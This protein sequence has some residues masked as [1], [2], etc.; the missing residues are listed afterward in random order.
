MCERKYTVGSVLRVG[1]DAGSTTVKVVVLDEQNNMIFNQYLRH[2]FDIRNALNLIFAQ[3]RT[4]LQNK[5]LAVMITGSSGI[6]L[7]NHLQLPFLQEVI[8][9]TQAV[10]R[11]IPEA[12]TVIE[13]GGEDAKITYFGAGV[14]QRMNNACAGGTGAFIDQ[15]AALL[16][17][18]PAGLNQLA[19]GYK[20]IYPIASRCGVFAKTD[21]QNLLNEGIPQ[22]DIAA[23]IL[24]AIVNQTISGLAQSRP[25]TGPVAFLGGPLHFMPELRQRFIET[26]ALKT[27]QIVSPAQAQ[28]FPAIGAALAQFPATLR[29]ERLLAGIAKLYEFA[30]PDR[31]KIEPLFATEA[32]Y[33]QFRQRHNNSAVAR[34][35]LAAYAGKAYLGIDAGSTTAKLAL[36]S[37]DGSLLYSHYSGNRGAPLENVITAL[38]KLY[39]SLPDNLTI[40]GSTVTGYGERLIKTA[41][42]A[43]VGEVET[44]AHYKASSRFLPG[45][46]FVLDIGGQDMKS[47]FVRNGVID[48]IILNEACSA[49]CG[50]FIETFA[51]SLNM[52]VTAFAALGLTAKTPV[53]L[54]SRCTVFMNSKVRQAQQEGRDMGDISAGIAIAIVKNA[55]YKVI[56]LKNPSDLGQK[57]VVQGGIFYNDAVLRALEKFLGREVVRPDI[58]GIMGAYGAALI[59]R[60]RCAGNHRSTILNSEELNNFTVQTSSRRCGLCGNNCLITAQNFSTGQVFRAGNR[61]EQGAGQENQENKENTAGDIPNI[62]NFKYQRVFNYNPLAAAAARRGTIGIPRVLNIY[63]DYPFWFT[64][65]TRLGYRVVLS[66]PSSRQLYETGI[67]AIPSESVCYPAKLVHGHMQDL[68]DKGIKKIFYPCI[69]LNIKEDPAADNCYNCPVVASYPENI[70]ANMDALVTRHVTFYHPFLPLDNPA[71]MTRRLIQELSPENLPAMAVNKAVKKAYAELARYK[72]EVRQKGEAILADIGA[73]GIRGIV[74]AGRPYHIDPEIN[75]GL[76]EMIQSYGQ[77]VLSED[78][79]RHLTPVERPLRVV[80]QWVYHSRLYACA[81]FVAQQPNLELIQLNSFGCGIDAIAIDQVHEI[82]AAH[83]KI[84]TVIK[85]DE[86]NNLGAARIRVRS[87]L[88]A[89]N[90]R[91]APL[92]PANASYRYRRRLFTPAMKQ[93]YTIIAPQMSP[94]H[95]QFLATI[96]QKFGYKAVFTPPA[97]KAAIDLGLRYVHNDACYPAIITVGQVL[98]ALQSGQYDINNTAVLM[99]QTGGGCRATN[100]IALIRK[101]LQDAQLPQVPV[102]SF[103]TGLEK[104]PGFKISL[105]MLDNAIMGLLYGDLLMQVLYRVRPYEKIPGS[106][107]RLYGHWVEQCQQALARGSKLA[108]WKNVAA[109]VRDFDNLAIREGLVKPKVG[110]AGEIFI[111][112]HPAANNQ[113]IDQLEREGAEVVVPDLTNFFLYCAYDGKVSH[114]LLSGNWH[115]IWGGTLLIQVVELYRRGMRQALQASQRFSPPSPIKEIACHAAKHLSLANLNGEGWFLT[116]EMVELILK[117]VTNIICAQPF[118]CLPNHIT[119]KGMLKE[120]RRSY[121]G[122]N[123]MSLDYDPGVSEVNLLNRIKLMLSVANV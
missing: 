87:L 58:A 54:G 89:T 111:K 69:P 19:K 74:L 32:E 28:Y 119:G 15:M 64:L 105:P 88:A 17:T 8:A 55:L 7:S 103:S 122:L 71:R 50:S 22:A 115:G 90:R 1:I 51:Q 91:T 43:D 85:L 112:Y 102:V 113:I 101:A 118:A 107:N 81:A 60:E 98:Q 114:Q 61:C 2:A 67:G 11:I 96:L 40:A 49:G 53:D 72:A 79:I 104:N 14:E 73:R 106:A 48:S 97:D 78:A 12:G 92:P 18:D 21:I 10:K 6:G 82:L 116:G 45:V 25:I 94:V 20:T 110:I 41:L 37:E 121:P 46:E 63:E 99:S 80:D 95:F 33:E 68:V 5:F 70:K 38:R 86:M 93:R 117:G 77:A 47:F 100:Y 3:A 29:H 34:K 36:I 84:H 39:Q 83:N 27:D 23:S 26:L 76:P 42:Q 30:D 57:I 62:Y 59:A 44:I 75:H 52:N 31:E 65:F 56:R 120:L 24:Q 9:C 16:H 35:D 4:L 66:G 109:I 108:F 123:V 13:L